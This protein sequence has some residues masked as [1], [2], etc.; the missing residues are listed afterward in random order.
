[1]QLGGLL[2]IIV[3]FLQVTGIWATIITQLQVLLANWQT[4]L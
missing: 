4:S 1:M 3:G 2:L